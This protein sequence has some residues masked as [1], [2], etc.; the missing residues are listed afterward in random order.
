MPPQPKPSL[1][2]LLTKA[3]EDAKRLANAQLALAKT[4]I[5]ASG[6]RFGTG[7]GLGIATL[8][9]AIFAVLFLLVTL[10]LGIAALGLPEWAGF[11]IVAVL[12]II[13]G[14]ITALVARK[15]FEKAS[16]PNLTMIEFEKTKA[17]LS[18]AVA[19]EMAPD[20]VVMPVTSPQES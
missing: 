7:A 11:L 1:K 5:S 9:I 13:A 6:Q 14:T 20:P 12:L 2:A 19:P 16:G 15:Q 10:A 4:E 3:A 18:G 8:G 17:A